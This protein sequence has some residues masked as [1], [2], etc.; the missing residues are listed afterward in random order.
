VG[1]IVRPNRQFI[2]KL[3][4]EL[5]TWEETFNEEAER[6]TGEVL[7]SRED[8]LIKMNEQVDKWTDVAMK[9]TFI[10]SYFSCGKP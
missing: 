10:A 6:F 8:E 9:V 1:T 3:H 7:L 5:K 2:A 4:Q